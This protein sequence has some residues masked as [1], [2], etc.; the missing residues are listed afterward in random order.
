M[1]ARGDR[2]EAEFEA[3]KC[4]L[5]TPTAACADL[6]DRGGVAN[7]LA[8]GGAV[9]APLAL[10]SGLAMLLVGA[11]RR[12]TVRYALIPVMTPTYAGFSLTWKWQVCQSARGR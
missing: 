3:A 9:V 4:S 12:A 8:I 11:R 2:L 6:I 10:G 5:Y 1:G 7:R